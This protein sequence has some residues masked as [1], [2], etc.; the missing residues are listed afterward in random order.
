MGPFIALTDKPW[1]DYLAGRRPERR[2]DEV[3]FWSPRSTEPLK[4]MTPGTPVFLRLKSPWNAIAG[5][6][7]YAHHGVY[8]L[9][10]AWRLFGTGNGDAFQASFLMRIGKFRGLDL[11]D[12]RVP[13]APLGCT[14]LRDVH[15][16]REDRWL[17]WG[18]E[19]EWARNI[20]RGAEERDPARAAL[21]LECIETDTVREAIGQELGTDYAL[22]Q[23]DERLR[24]QACVVVREG[25]GTFRARLL[26]AYGRS[27]AVTGEHTEPVL[28]AA[29]IQPYLGSQSN[30]PQ[31]GLLLTQEFHTLF[32]LGL[33][34]VTPG[35]EVRVSSALASR[36]GNGRRYRE[37][38]GK[39]LRNLPREPRL[40]PS[41]R[42]L[43]WHNQARFVSS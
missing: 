20:V 34:T 37:Y 22:V 29:H 25:Q 21:L 39:R 13:Q 15:F 11:L 28:D 31:N 30:H 17:R 36:W 27:C 33:M 9:D 26:D 32:D 1:F 18:A 40:R 43:A 42:A 24:R 23:D 2:A 4:A 10:E 14:V 7:F 19:R 41:P 5:Y 35:Y 6:G 16:W 12:A 38:D 3:N 8:T